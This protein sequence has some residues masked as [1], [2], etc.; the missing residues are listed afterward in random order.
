MGKHE[1]RDWNMSFVSRREQPTS[2]RGIAD[3]DRLHRRES[4]LEHH[5]RPTVGP[6]SPRPRLFLAAGSLHPVNK[7]YLS[8]GTLRLY[9]GRSIII[10]PARTPGEWC[11]FPEFENLLKH[12]RRLG[13]S[14][15]WAERTAHT[16]IRYCKDSYL[17]EVMHELAVSHVVIKILLWLHLKTQTWNDSWTDPTGCH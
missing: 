16:Q 5:H 3:C 7:V 9:M 11:V 8:E 1:T 6:G 10:F 2:S 12:P 15:D 13:N 4:V 17:S 14:S